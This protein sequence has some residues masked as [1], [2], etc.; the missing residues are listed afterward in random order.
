MAA[1]QKITKSVIDRLPANPHKDI[2]IL[3]SQVKGFGIRRKP[4][5][6]TSFVLQYR[7]AANT[8]RRMTIGRFGEITADQARGLALRLRVKINEG[9]DPACKPVED[10]DQGDRIT[11]AELCWKNI[12]SAKAGTLVTA[13]GRNKSPSTI[14]NE[15]G[16]IRRHIEPTIGSI[17]AKELTSAQIKRMISDIT[18]GATAVD[19]KTGSRGR[20]I[21][22]GGAPVARRVLEMLGGVFSWA[23][24]QEIISGANPCAGIRKRKIEPRNRVLTPEEYGRLGA[25]IRRAEQTQHDA[26]KALHLLALTGMRREEACGMQW[27]EFDKSGS[28]V[29]LEKTKTGRSMRPLG[30]D[31]IDLISQQPHVA[32]WIFPNR[33]ATGSSDFKKRFAAILKDAGLADV[34]PHD[35]R[36]SFAT[37]AAIVGYSDGIIGELIG[38]AKSGV[39]SVHYIRR[40]DDALVAAANRVAEQVQLLLADTSADVLTFPIHKK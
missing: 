9:G 38:H 5:G 23:L 24:E 39:T 16:W 29:R 7:N 22:R 8:S 18:A 4:S 3:D 2:L 37:Q 17:K 11:V 14:S 1:P 33:S 32:E 26:A 12:E 27:R 35:L 10:S 13:R 19:I 25:A 30:R 40:P 28:C 20:A 21:A 6:A 36:R 15:S 34:H 31:A